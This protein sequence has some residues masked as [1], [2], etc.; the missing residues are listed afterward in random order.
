MAVAWRRK[1]IPLGAALLLVLVFVAAIVASLQRKPQHEAPVVADLMV[2]DSSAA[3]PTALA[4]EPPPAEVPAPAESDSGSIAPV[5]VSVPKLAYTYRLGF[6]LP[7]D[8][9]AE[10]QEAHRALCLRMGPSR[11]QLLAMSRSAEG[12]AQ[13]PARLTLRVASIEAKAFSD[14]L[15]GI[16]S[17]S[18]GK[19]MATSVTAE[20]VSKAIVDAEARIRQ[21]EL[22]V[23][24][25]TEILRTRR[26]TVGELV[27]AE[28]SVAEAQEE[29]DQTKGWLTELRGRV[30]MSEFEIGYSQ[31][32]APKAEEVHEG[33]SILDAL[34]GSAGGFL[35]SLR[36]VL[37]I[38]I[39][40]APWVLIG[41][42]VALWVR[43]MAR[44]KRDSETVAAT[45]DA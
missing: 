5:A 19:T 2:S 33:P 6:R 18:G 10:V 44:R 1:A 35:M 17:G 12:E 7:G 15:T 24:R 34:G 29:L 37:L 13:A 39:Y 38:L 16:V 3:A 23:A 30:A 21:R 28:R 41:V 20:D 14:R 43:R 42:P 31:A 9:L 27:E 11:C 32:E 26:G 25:L 36:I 22:L 45:A 4:S 40:L 8:K